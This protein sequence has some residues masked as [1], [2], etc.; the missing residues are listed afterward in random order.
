MPTT[1]DIK[2][3]KV[4]YSRSVSS[5][6]KMEAGLKTSYVASEDPPFFF[7]LG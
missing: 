5:K 6:W 2:T 3:A 1:I 7:L 4:D